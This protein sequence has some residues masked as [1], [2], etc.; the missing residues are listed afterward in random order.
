MTKKPSPGLVPSYVASLKSYVPGKPIEEVERE[1]GLTAIKLASNENALG[2]SPK[3]IEALQRFLSR[4]HRYPDAAGTYLREKL[5]ARH[6]LG[7]EHIVLGNGSTELIQLLCH[8]YLEPGKTG[9]TS[10]GTFVMFPLGVRSAGGDV[11]QVPLKDL[12]YDLEALAARIDDSVRILYLANPNNPTGTLFT[13]SEMDRFLGNVPE[14]VLVVLDEAYCDYVQ[15]PDYSRS[16]DYV[17]QGR[18]LIVLRTFSKVHGLAGLRIG[19]G[20]GHPEVVD[21]LNKIRSPFNVSNLALVAAEAALDDAEHIRRSVE[22]NRR[23][24]QFLSRELPRLGL[25]CVPSFANFMYCESGRDAKEDFRALL[26]MGVIVRPMGFMGLPR[27][28]RVT[29]GTEEENRKV[30]EALARLQESSSA[31]AVSR[32]RAGD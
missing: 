10:Q 16:L 5:S 15:R 23:G 30:V 19:Y 13:A 26:K 21:A 20:L 3:A 6:E 8:I 1:L 17:R 27:G 32:Q 2:P 29:V 7:L 12:A 25:R 14:N 24:L 22:S 4:S 11:V 28:L 31:A 18:Y 9:L